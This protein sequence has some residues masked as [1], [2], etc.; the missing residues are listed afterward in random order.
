MRNDDPVLDALDCT[1]LMSDLQMEMDEVD[2][3]IDDVSEADLELPCVG[4]D[5]GV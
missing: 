5:A 3:P 4:D 2:I 1:A